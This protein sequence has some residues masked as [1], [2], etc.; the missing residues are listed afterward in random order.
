ME[1]TIKKRVFSGIQ[2]TGGFTLGNYL[3]AVKNWKQMQ[4]DYNCIYCVVDEHALT[5]RNEPSVLRRQIREA[6]S[7]LIALGIDPE[8][9]ILFVQSHVSAHAELSWLLSCYTQFGEL[10]RMT[11]FKD[12]AQKHPDNINAGLFTYP[13]L[14]A[15]DIL[16]YDTD[17]VPV[18][19]DQ[20]QH[21]ELARNIAI[22]FNGIYGDTFVVPEG[23]YQKIG[24]KVMS[25]QDPTAKMSKSD[26]NDNA[27]IML[28]DAPEVI[29]RKIKRAV[30]DSGSEVKPGEGKEGV[31]NLMTIYAA[32][33]GKT[34]E[35]VENEFAGKGYGVFKAAVADAVAEELRPVQAE[36]A[37]IL[38][39]REYLDSVLKN[40]S[41]QAAKIA[42]KVLNR[43]RKR[44]GLNI[45]R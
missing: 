21:I 4:D 17:C 11:Q 15:A 1:E 5:V 25:L 30:T 3:G 20:R 33:N 6:A 8:K 38:A 27:K 7:M 39:D 42:Y 18:G 34:M 43:T 19:I 22:R 31:E 41:E 36:Y 44:L 24:A 26:P 10:S 32:I 14:M 45:F 37:R 23:I 12:K 2:P 9:S 16:L 40:G 28:T 35:E 13:V 29:V